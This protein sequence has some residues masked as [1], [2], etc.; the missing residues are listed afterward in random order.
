MDASTSDTSGLIGI[1]Q[2]TAVAGA[3]VDVAGRGLSSCEFAGATT[4]GNYVQASP[5]SAGLCEDAGPTYPISGVQILGRVLSTNAVAGTYTVEL[6]SGEE[7]GGEQVLTFDSP[8]SRSTNAISCPTCEVTGNKNAAGGYAG[9]DS[10]SKLNALQLPN[11]GSTT[12]GGIQSFAAQANR[13]INAISTAGVPSAAQ[14][15]ASDLSNG[16][17]GSGAVVLATSPTITTPTISG[18]LGSN[19]SLGTGKATVFEIANDSTTGTTLNKLA[20]LTGDPSKAVVAGTSDIGGMIGIVVGSAGTTGNA[21][22]AISGVAGCA[23]DGATVA[24]D[25]VEISP[26]IAGNCRDAGSTRPT[27]KQIIGIVLVT[28]ALAGTNAVRLFGDEIIGGPNVVTL[29]S[30]VTNNNATANTI[31]D[32]TGLSFSVVSGRTYRFRALI[33]YTAAATSTGSRWA[34]NGPATSLLAYNSRYSLT[35]TTQTTNYLNAYNTPATSNATSAT[36]TGNIAI[37]EG[38]LTPTASGTVVVR[39]ASEVANSAIV[40]KAGSILEWW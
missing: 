34:I 40:A 27:S 18:A 28:N 32:V 4:A 12:L 15:A 14:P 29:T 5:T 8:L 16:T 23:F 11:P 22:I 26:T 3:A 13:F 21:Q 24:G 20:K 1:A 38:I 2:A 39:F 36:T 33:A 9:L 10:N 25:Y 19:L 6:F 7:R 37:I 17:N 31:A 35:T 30:D